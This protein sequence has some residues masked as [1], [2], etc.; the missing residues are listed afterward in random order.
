VDRDQHPVAGL[1][2]LPFEL[3]P[4]VQGRRRAGAPSTAVGAGGHPGERAE[5]VDDQHPLGEPGRAQ[6]LAAQLPASDTEAT[7][8]RDEQATALQAQIRKLETQQNAQITALEDVPDG[9][10]GTDMR[11]RINARFAELHAQRTAAEA[12]LA[13]I[14][15]ETPRA[16]DPSLLDELPYLGD[17]L[18]G[19]PPALKTRLFDTFDLT[20]TW[21][22]AKDG[23]GVDQVTVT[24]V[25]TDET[26]T[27]LPEINPRQDGYHDTV[28]TPLTST[29][30][31][32]SAEPPMAGS[33][34]HGERA[35]G[36]RR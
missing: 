23:D 7:A 18:P 21:N 30:I 13:S 6:L 14:T 22:K 2:S 4:L 20:V 9:P 3:P 19:L 29:A 28:P 12:Q 26:L 8:R 33:T 34:A 24:A 1:A 32:H 16:A 17:I 5:L 35:G 31:G 10:A 15:A 25:L 11:A 36:L 27:A